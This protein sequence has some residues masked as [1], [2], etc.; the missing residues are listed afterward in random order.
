MSSTHANAAITVVQ[1]AY[2]AVEGAKVVTATVQDLVDQGKT[3]FVANNETLGD[4]VPGIHKHFAMNYRVGSTLFSFACK[5]NETVR[6]RTQ[7]KPGAFTVIGAAY[8]A[9][10]PNNPTLGSRDVTA[11][12]QQILD[13]GQTEFQ[14]NNELFGDPNN[15]FVKNFGMTYFRTGSPIPQKAIVSDEGQTVK[16]T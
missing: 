3:T 11:I 12:V 1:A 9:T 10:D 2:G 16:V 8:G 6:L 14:T 15:G 7:E 4:P 13:S 5:E